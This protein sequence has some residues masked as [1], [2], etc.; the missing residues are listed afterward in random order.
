ML[1]TPVKILEWT[2][3]YAV[4][5]GE[6]DREHQSLFAAINHLHEAMLAGHGADILGTLLADLDRYVQTHFAH[7]EQLMV[8]SRYPGLQAHVQ[9]HEALQRRAK[10]LLTRFEHGEVTMTIELTLLLSEW[11][12]QHTMTTDRRLGEYLIES[13]H[14]RE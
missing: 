1:T 14:I 12:R 4:H 3:E 5:V 2:P 11:L 8:D 10:T 7:E 9:Q 13:G 6:I